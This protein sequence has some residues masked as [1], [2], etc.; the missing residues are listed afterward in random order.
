LSGLIAK[1]VSRHLH[2]GKMRISVYQGSNRSR[3]SD[4]LLTNDIVL[5]NYDTIRADW[6]SQGHNGSIHSKSWARVVLDEGK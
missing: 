4:D 5:T 6:A 2:P 1:L 3:I